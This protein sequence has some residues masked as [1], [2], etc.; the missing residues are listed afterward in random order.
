MPTTTVTPRSS[1]ASTA[2]WMISAEYAVRWSS[3]SI[4]T[5]VPAGPMVVV[6]SRRGADAT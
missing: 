4:C 1:A 3:N 2:P 6:P 5:V